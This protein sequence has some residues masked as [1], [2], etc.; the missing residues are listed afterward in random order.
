MKTILLA[1]A[2]AVTAT[3]GAFAQSSALDVFTPEVSQSGVDFSA[4]ASI[5][6]GATE[7]LGPRLG[8][9]SPVYTNDVRGIDF[10]AT[11]SIGGAPEEL[12][13]RLGDGSPVY[14]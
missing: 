6:D 13:P 4:T 10:R 8:D 14:N 1:A 12:G 3:T 5:G 9:G 7:E 2:I 11:A